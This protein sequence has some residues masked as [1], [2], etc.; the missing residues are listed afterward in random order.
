[1]DKTLWVTR[2]ELSALSGFRLPV[3]SVPE[4]A[5][6]SPADLKLRLTVPALT[7]EQIRTLERYGVF[8]LYQFAYADTRQGVTVLWQRPKRRRG[9][10]ARYSLVDVATARLYGWLKQVSRLRPEL[11]VTHARIAASLRGADA[12][13]ALLSLVLRTEP[14]A[15]MFVQRDALMLLT[16]KLVEKYVA[17][18]DAGIARYGPRWSEG[19]PYAVLPLRWLG[20]RRDVLPRVQKMRAREPEV[21]AFG[22]YRQEVPRAATELRV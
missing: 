16:D 22:R 2:G 17:Y 20:M 8:D 10:T 1:M 7:T 4:R 3:S 19:R 5:H 11:E 6:L 15:A 12:V 13:R 21:W 14:G 9:E 18:E